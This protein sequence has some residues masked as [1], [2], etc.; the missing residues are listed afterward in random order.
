MS[1]LLGYWTV[2]TGN[3]SLLLHQLIKAPFKPLR[4]DSLKQ[5]TF[6][7]VFLLA[8]ASGKH[9]SE[10]HA[11]MNRDIY[12]QD[13][14]QV[15]LYPSPSFLFKNQLAHE[16]PYIV[17]PVVIQALGATLDK[18]LKDDRSLCPLI[19]H[20]A[21]IWRGPRTSEAVNNWFL[22][23]LGILGHF[24]L[25]NLFLDKLSVHFCYKISNQEALQVL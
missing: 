10:I 7:T 6:T 3:L 14:S 13:W 17:A 20:C 25:Y 24:T 21:T 1:T 23:P 11:C 4:K 12:H 2:S 22:P 15:S 16:G 18:S 5:L 19:E 9:R 8:L